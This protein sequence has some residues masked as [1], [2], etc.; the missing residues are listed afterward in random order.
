MYEYKIKF[1]IRKD[2]LELWKNKQKY[3]VSALKKSRHGS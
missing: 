3:K 2:L 1:D